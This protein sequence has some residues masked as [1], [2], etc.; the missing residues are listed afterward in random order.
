MAAL[1]QAQ[2]QAAA[3][4]GAQDITQPGAIEQEGAV[5]VPASVEGGA[6]VAR[7][8]VNRDGGLKAGEQEA[9]PEE[10]QEYE[11]ALSALH[12]VLYSNEGTSQA[13]VD[14]LQP[15]DKVGSVAKAGI[16]VVQQL[17]EKIDL[18]ESVFAEITM[19]I[20][21][22]LIEMGE[23]AKGMEFSEKESQAVMGATWEGVMELY[24][25]D[26]S[27]YEE[28]TQGMSP[29]ELKGYEQEYKGYL[30]E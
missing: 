4:P 17:D 28:L 3:E 2:Q 27:A 7:A 11:K 30:G 22:R 26:E 5:G 18:D 29:E 24:G 1:E 15:Q 10:Q 8:S 9:S 23:R 12:T 16:L 14:M 20:A 6:S 19:D 21:D 13:I 25:I